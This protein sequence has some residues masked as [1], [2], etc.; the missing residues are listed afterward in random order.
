MVTDDNE[1]IAHASQIIAH[2]DLSIGRADAKGA[3]LA[4]REGE[5][6]TVRGKGCPGE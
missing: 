5:R 4:G 2:V 3:D 6:T 1:E